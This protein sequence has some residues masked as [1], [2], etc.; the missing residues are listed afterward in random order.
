MTAEEDRLYRIKTG[1]SIIHKAQRELRKVK[2]KWNDEYIIVEPILLFD[3]HNNEDYHLSPFVMEFNQFAK[4]F[5]LDMVFK[6]E[7]LKDQIDPNQ[8]GT[9]NLWSDEELESRIKGV[10]NAKLIGRVN[11]PTKNR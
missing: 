11:F 5:Q 6:M 2:I 9:V 4:S 7:M 3:Y 8:N 1:L 10:S